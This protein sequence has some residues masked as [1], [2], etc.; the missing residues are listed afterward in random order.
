MTAPGGEQSRITYCTLME[1]IKRRIDVIGQLVARKIPL[2]LIVASELGYLQLRMVAELIAIGCL[3]AHGDIGGARSK[4][5]RNAYSADFIL[6]RLGDLHADFY[7]IP[8]KQ[9]LDP[10]TGQ[11][12]AI[13]DIEEPYLTKEQLFELYG[14]CGDFLH[15]GT[16]Q[17]LFDGIQPTPNL[18][19]IGKWQKRIVALL[20][21]HQIRF[22][23]PDYMLCVIMQSKS[24]GGVSAALFQRA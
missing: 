10:E 5:L 13:H 12:I 15:R 16:L 19:R 4:K 9:E 2:P 6:K 8:G 18:S 17:D 7:P 22:S 20:N 3:V 23:N 21:H 14:E 1:E 11:P 24:D